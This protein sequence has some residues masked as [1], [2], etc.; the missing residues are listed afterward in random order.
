MAEKEFELN[1]NKSISK[2]LGRFMRKS[3]KAQG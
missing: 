2:K 1:K 3:W